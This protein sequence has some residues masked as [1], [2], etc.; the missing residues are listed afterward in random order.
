MQNQIK[1]VAFDAFGTLVEIRDKRRPYARLAKAAAQPLARSPMCEP[2]DLDAM[3][4]L[5]GLTLDASEMAILHADLQAELASTQPYPEAEEVLKEL[6]GLGVRIAVASN[7]ALPYAR[8]IEE[9]FG[10]LLDVSCMSFEVGFVKPD[11]GFYAELCRR[12][13]HL[14]QEVLMIG[15]TWRCDYEGAT[16]AGLH[17][18][19]LDRQGKIEVDQS[20]VFSSNLCSVL[21]YIGGRQQSNSD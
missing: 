4:H 8:P 11:A 2:I 5:C 16:V 17:A 13:N 7:L 20:Y 6:R 15:D 19:H 1:A 10:H 3:V 21:A 12:L 14:P 18:I 9:K